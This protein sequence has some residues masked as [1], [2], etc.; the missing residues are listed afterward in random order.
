MT[1]LNAATAAP[2]RPGAAT[3]LTFPRVARAEWIKAA[4]LR[5][6]YW[7]IGVSVGSGSVTPGCAPAVPAT[8]TS[9]PVTSS[10]LRTM[11]ISSLCTRAESCTVWG[12]LST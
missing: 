6:T 10:D 7:T 1:T 11:A 5:S 2:T 12:H 8:V 9:M 3:R 4:T